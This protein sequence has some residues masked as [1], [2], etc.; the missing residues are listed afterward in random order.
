MNLVLLFLEIAA[1]SR[2]LSSYQYDCNF[3]L[4]S[5]CVSFLFVEE[6]VRN[7]ILRDSDYVREPK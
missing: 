4:L 6:R 7:V 1:E 5:F 2:L 3:L